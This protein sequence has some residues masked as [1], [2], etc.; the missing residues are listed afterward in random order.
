LLVAEKRWH[1]ITASVLLALLFT[2]TGYMEQ[3]A[4]AQ[5][6]EDSNFLTYTN[7]FLGLT[8][9]YPSNWKII[10]VD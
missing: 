5:T 8:F 1:V 4:S 9:K 6:T 3:I 7:T 2:L 10:G